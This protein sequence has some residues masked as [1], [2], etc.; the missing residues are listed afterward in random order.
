M[1][2]PPPLGPRPPSEPFSHPPGAPRELDATGDAYGEESIRSEQARK[3][4][5]DPLDPPEHF[6]VGPRGPEPVA[7]LPRLPV[8][9]SLEE[10]AGAKH[11]EHPI[12]GREVLEAEQ[13]SLHLC[14]LGLNLW[15]QD[16]ERGLGP[17][18]SAQSRMVQLQAL[19]ADLR[20][21]AER[22]DA[23][24][25]FGEG[26]AQRS[27]PQAR[28]TLEQVLRAFRAHQNS[29]FWQLWR[30]QAQLVSTSLVWPILVVPGACASLNPHDLC[31]LSRCW[32]RPAHWNRT[33]SSRGTQMGRAL[34]G[35]GGPGHPVASPHQQSWN[36]TRRGT[37]GTLSLWGEG[38]SP[39]CQGLR[40]SCVATG[41]PRAEDKD[42]RTCSCRASAAGSTQ[43][44]TKDNPCSGSLEPQ[45]LPGRSPSLSWALLHGG[46]LLSNTAAPA[47]TH[48]LPTGSLIPGEN[49]LDLMA[50]K[51]L[52]QTPASPPITVAKLTEGSDWPGL[53]TCLV[54]AV[55]L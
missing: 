26:L 9:S 50:A 35:S 38:Q 22:L 45:I 25:V 12:S 41:A 34:V 23:L 17:C 37:L 2:Q 5:Q 8:P 7:N 6:R 46:F 4:G 36:G 30:L 48:S 55:E 28:A 40:V 49:A 10:S 14:L 18:V 19:Q 42:W 21:A 1:A 16:W 54:M 47:A 3:L 15:L 52:G 53:V 51:V 13:D 33:W 32:R 27:E 20:G 29:I 43:Q 11:P 44:V 31:P 39:G 24:L